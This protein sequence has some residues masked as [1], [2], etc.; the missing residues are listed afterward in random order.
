MGH[1]FLL[2]STGSLNELARRNL[3]TQ[4][5]PH[6]ESHCRLRISQHFGESLLRGH[7]STRRGK[8]S[9]EPP[10][11]IL[12]TIPWRHARCTVRSKWMRIKGNR[13]CQT[14]HSGPSLS[15]AL[16]FSLELDRTST[17]RM[18]TARCTNK[19]HQDHSFV[20]C[21]AVQKYTKTSLT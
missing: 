14:F 16:I 7:H 11:Q 2:S 1:H 4:S 18:L 19:R 12:D 21:L 8:V 3:G 20:P 15:R 13:T 5:R 17:L 6:K 9:M 10:L